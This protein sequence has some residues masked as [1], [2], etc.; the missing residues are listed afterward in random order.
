MIVKA[1]MQKHLFTFFTL[2]P[3]QTPR[4][5]LCHNTDFIYFIDLILQCFSIKQL[6]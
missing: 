5:H 4:K 2:Y 3:V 6:S 1:Y